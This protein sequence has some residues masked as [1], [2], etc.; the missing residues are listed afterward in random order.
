MYEIS[1]KREFSESVHRVVA[2]SETSYETCLVDT[3]YQYSPSSHPLSEVEVFAGSVL[4][5]NGGLPSKQMREVEKEMKNKV[6]RDV[7]FTVKSI[8]QGFGGTQ[9][10]TRDEALA[11]SI[12][13]LAVAA[14][15]PGTVLPKIG[16]LRSFAYVAAA[17]CLREI[18]GFHGAN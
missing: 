4:G 16:K 13:C 10:Q 6:E 11:R 17:V 2:K 9:E 14:E 18:D 15:E 7:S 1:K 12:A 5:K 3:M 8:L